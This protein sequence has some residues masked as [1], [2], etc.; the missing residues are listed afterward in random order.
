MELKYLGNKK[1]KL[2]FKKTSFLLRP[3]DSDDL[4]F[5]KKGIVIGGGKFLADDDYLMVAGAGEYERGGNH[6]KAI[7]VGGSVVYLVE[8]GGIKVAYL[9]GM[10]EE[11]NEKEL[12]KVA[13]L[14]ADV[15]L[16]SLDDK[17]GEMLK[18]LPTWLRKWGVNYVVPMGYKKD[19]GMLKSFLDLFDVEG[20]EKE[21]VLKIGSRIE[22]PE[23]M[24]IVVLE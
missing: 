9:E 17:Q 3:K 11:P 24:E 5:L 23:G 14:E 15:M 10:V 13:D 1:F 19:D 2:K 6:I 18:K 21:E 20:K 8:V 12:S 16:F 4:D 22:L 7:E